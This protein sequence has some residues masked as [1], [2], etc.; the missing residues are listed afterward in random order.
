MDTTTATAAKLEAA[1]ESAGVSRLA[2]SEASGIARTTL[3]RILDGKRPATVED[4]DFIAAALRV[5][6]TTLVEFKAAAA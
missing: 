3:N 1:R 2:L 5:D 6:P 4:V